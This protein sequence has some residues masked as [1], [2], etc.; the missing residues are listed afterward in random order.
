MEL[1]KGLEELMAL[2]VTEA[3]HAQAEALEP[4][5]LF[6]AACK[7]NQSPL[8]AAWQSA[9]ID[10]KALRRR[11]RVVAYGTNA[12]SNSGPTRLSSRVWEILSNATGRAEALKRELPTVEVMISLLRHP[13]AALTQIFAREKLPVE[14]LVQ[15]LEGSGVEAAVDEQTLAST[16]LMRGQHPPTPT[17][18][19]H[20]KDYT[21][22]AQAGKFDPVIGRREEIKQVVRILLQKQKNNPVLVGEAGVGKTSVVEGLAL[23]LVAPD[24]PAELREWR[25]VEVALSSL[26]AGMKYRGEFEERLQQMIKEAESDQQLILFLDEIHMLV[27]AGASGGAMDAANI[28]KPALARGR[29]RLIGATTP[30][31]YRQHIENDSALERRLQPVRIEEPTPE[32]AREILMGLVSTYEAHHKVE[33]S[34]EAIDAAVELSIKHIPD[35]RLPDKAR[36]LIDRAAVAKRFL[37]F[38]PATAAEADR[39]RITRDDVAHVV[40]EWT[41]IPVERLTA[42]EQLRLLGMEQALRK[43]VIG[44]DHAVEAVAHLVKTAMSGLSDPTHPYGV[45]LFMGPTGV[46]KTELAK[47]LAEFLF[48]D[49]RQL[50]RFDMSEY[51]E[52]H[53]VSKLIGA[54]PGYIGHDQGGLLTDAVR[55]T[56]YCVLLFDEVEK[57]HPRVSDIFLQIF[58]DGRLTDSRGRTADFC[59]TVIILT[60]NL[61]DANEHQSMQGFRPDDPADTGS[62]QEHELSPEDVRTLLLSRFRPELINRFSRIIQFHR[63]GTDQVREII[64]KLIARVQE[65]VADKNIELYLVPSAHDAL[66]EVG[67]KQE[68]GAREMERVIEQLVVQPLAQGLLTGNFKAGEV[69]YVVSDGEGIT[70]TTTAPAR[71]TSDPETGG[72]VF[73]TTMKPVGRQQVAMLLCDVVKSTDLVRREGDTFVM[74]QM[75]DIQDAIRSHRTASGLRFMKFTGDGFLLLYDDVAMAIDVARALR[76]LSVS[77]PWNLRFVI[78]TGAVRIELGGDPIGVEVHRLFRIEALDQTQHVVRTGERNLPEHSLIVIT[79][80]ALNQL[81]EEARTEFEPLGKFRLKGFDELEEIWVE[82]GNDSRLV[83]TH[84]TKELAVRV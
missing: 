6:V 39:P 53:T 24:A 62:S 1:P 77:A 57:A 46:G 84:C 21:V 69:I 27:G 65:R 75:R 3:T 45:F 66:M 9:E 78:H 7:L 12:R 26:V 10:P 16:G 34:S 29:M 22:L 59:H 49:E 44:Q 33:I 80:A 82:K 47:A 38:T 52:E 68:W 14:K 73:L 20:G 48:G 37:S 36:D 74:R 40:A 43:R 61:N 50:V 25:I 70:L 79:P 60:T 28:L 23:R 35:R 76:S 63:L 41:G 17:I 4:A 83:V 18:D 19:R 81:S 2:A 11:V 42:D 15:Y 58:D 64:N 51:M 31:E 67:Y 5:H 54:P 55:Q 56:P 72:K 71:K 13:D 30:D 32:Q 8:S